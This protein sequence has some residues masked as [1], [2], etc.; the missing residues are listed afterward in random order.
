MIKQ[1]FN[2]AKLLQSNTDPAQIALGAVLG[3]FF[4]FTPSHQTHLIL[5]VLLFFFLKINRGA[6]M[7]VFPV[8]K[9]IYLVGLWQIAD[10]VGYYLLTESPVPA[11]AW[12]FVIHAPVLALLRLDHTLILGG[13]TLAAVIG[14]PVFIVVMSA[15]YAYRATFAEK[16]GR[17]NVVKMLQGLV[18]V[19]W[20]SDR[21]GK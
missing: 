1:V 13:M 20:F 14:V 16:V 11:A 19:K 8:A 6:A 5:L 2:L 10:Q 17:W 9:L 15:V 21:W 7:L 18:F 4:G 12:S 3:L